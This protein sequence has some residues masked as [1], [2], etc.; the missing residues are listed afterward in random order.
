MSRA[1]IP[2]GN[3]ANGEVVVP[4]LQPFPAKGTGYHRH[5]FI[6][7][8]QDKRLDLSEYGIK[9]PIDLEAR[10]FSTL[11]FYRKYQEN[12]TPAGLSFFQSDWDTSLTDFYH[13]ELG[14]YY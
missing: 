8:K 7:Y 13:K 6:L 9:A 10:T 3:V 12:L 5:I 4:Y 2:N 1:N 11:D 14:K